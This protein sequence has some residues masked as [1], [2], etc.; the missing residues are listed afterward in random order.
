M[1]IEMLIWLLF[2]DFWVMLFDY[3][4]IEYR[5]WSRDFVVLLYISLMISFK[6]LSYMRLKGFI[7]KELNVNYCSKNWS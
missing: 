5:V 2:L 1:G 7:A 6:E 4:E 3:V